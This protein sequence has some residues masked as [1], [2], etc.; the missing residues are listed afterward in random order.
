MITCEIGQLMP[1]SLDFCSIADRI[2]SSQPE[3]AVCGLWPDDEEKSVNS[4]GTDSKW[5]PT[6]GMM[7]GQRKVSAEQLE[8]ARRATEGR[9]FTVLVI[10]ENG[11]IRFS[12]GE[13]FGVADKPLPW[14][15][16]E[17][18]YSEEELTVIVH[19]TNKLARVDDFWDAF[20]QLE[21]QRHS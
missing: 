12:R 5:T 16:F 3:L 19:G 8:S 1:L 10:S 15:P 14:I 9:D 4:A 21:A 18:V 11:K 17:F 2:C 13:V 20:E 7:Q 6:T